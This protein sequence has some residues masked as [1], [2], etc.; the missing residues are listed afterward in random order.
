MQTDW[1]ETQSA[2]DAWSSKADSST[3]ILSALSVY[4]VVCDWTVMQWSSVQKHNH[5]FGWSNSQNL[6][7]GRRT[8][9]TVTLNLSWN[10]LWLTS[11]RSTSNNLESPYLQTRSPP[12]T[13]PIRSQTTR[14][15]TTFRNG[16]SSIVSCCHEEAKPENTQILIWKTLAWFVLV[17]VRSPTTT[18]N[19]MMMSKP[20][21]VGQ[22]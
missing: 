12:G 22:P 9:A 3:R 5:P 13:V 17:Q 2:I 7:S 6:V 18:R 11:R 14:E 1:T 10:P 20:H 4:R 16:L 21:R 19:S 8:A 15:R